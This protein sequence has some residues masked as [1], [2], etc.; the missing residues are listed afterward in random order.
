LLLLQLLRW[1]LLLGLLL[2][3]RQ[4]P[5]FE[6]LGHPA[7][8]TAWRVRPPG[9]DSWQMRWCDSS[10][11]AECALCI[12]DGKQC[13]LRRSILYQKCKMSQYPEQQGLRYASSCL[14]P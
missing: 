13:N 12:L 9:N 3:R 1:I 11:L 2:V 5:V 7:G 6:G 10:N 4:P 8:T 14:H